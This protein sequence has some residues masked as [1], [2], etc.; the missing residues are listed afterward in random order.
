MASENQLSEIAGSDIG[1]LASLRELD[2][3]NNTLR[4]VNFLSVLSDIEVDLCWP[5]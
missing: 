5:R 4:S 2:L 1:P 3:S